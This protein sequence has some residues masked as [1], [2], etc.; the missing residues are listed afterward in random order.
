M[1]NTGGSVANNP[2]RDS[3]IWKI[4]PC[5]NVGPIAITDGQRRRLHK[6]CNRGVWFTGLRYTY[7]DRIIANDSRRN[8]PLDRNA[9]Q[10]TT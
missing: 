8:G 3:E 10:V 4:L 5:S 6:L 1:N 7:I 2:T 9:L